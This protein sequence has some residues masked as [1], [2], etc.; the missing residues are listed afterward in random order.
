M[1]ATDLFYSRL[2]N[3]RKTIGVSNLR[4]NWRCQ[5]FKRMIPLALPMYTGTQNLALFFLT[6]HLVPQ[7]R[8]S[9]IN[10]RSTLTEGQQMAIGRNKER[11]FKF[12]SV[13]TQQNK[14]FSP[15]GL[16]FVWITARHKLKE[17]ASAVYLLPVEST[18][19][20]YWHSIYYPLCLLVFWTGIL[21]WSV[22]CYYLSA[23]NLHEM[24]W[25]HLFI[26]VYLLDYFPLM[27]IGCCHIWREQMFEF[28]SQSV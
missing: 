11:S 3:C 15:F 4:N 7:W 27:L 10:V 14:N 13:Q 26:W 2:T 20:K 6:F 5:G 9:W 28:V 8:D 1:I 24:Y 22:Q 16:N 21:K 19:A 23:C 12:N 25:C 18:S 17:I